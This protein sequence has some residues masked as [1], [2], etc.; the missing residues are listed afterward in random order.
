MGL[1]AGYVHEPFVYRC[2]NNVS[3]KQDITAVKTV[4]ML[5][6]KLSLG[7]HMSTVQRPFVHVQFHYSVCHLNSEALGKTPNNL[8]SSEAVLTPPLVSKHMMARDK[9]EKARPVAAFTQQC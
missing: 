7:S 2:L 8:C 5:I 3:S 9:D 6:T 1:V 4:H